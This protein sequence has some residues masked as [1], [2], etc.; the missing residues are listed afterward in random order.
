MNTYRTLAWVGLVFFL[1]AGC[2]QEEEGTV[3]EILSISPADGATGVARTT[4]IEVEFSDP[5][6][7]ES[8]ESRFALV[9]GEITSLPMMG[10]MMGD[11]HG[12]FHWDEDD[13]MMTFH[14]D[15][16]LMDS[17][18]YSICL[19][20]GMQ[21]RDGSWEMTMG[22]MRP[23]GMESEGGIISHFTTGSP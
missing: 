10:G 16:T 22:G 19:W 15:S 11:I 9:H 23:H 6:D 8:C 21:N 3:P 17:S 20:E 13:M 12:E 2:G 14:P 18:D 5:M 1:F 4:A 7:R